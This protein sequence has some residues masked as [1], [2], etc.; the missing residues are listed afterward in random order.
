MDLQQ[1]LA[2]LE[3]AEDFLDFFELEYD[4]AVVQVNRLHILQRYHD[5]L[6][7]GSEVIPE[8]ESAKRAVYRRLLARAYQDFV[9]SDALHEKVF[10]VFRMHEP[11]TTFVPIDGLLASAR[12]ATAQSDSI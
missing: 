6:H 9:D 12:R 2:S 8:D 4:P 3:S 10:K 5:Y 11:Q 1:E 7:Q